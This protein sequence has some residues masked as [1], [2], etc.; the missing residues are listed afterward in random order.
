MATNRVFDVICPGCG[1]VFHETTARF[2]KSDPIDGSMLYL[3]EP[4]RTEYGWSS[5]IEEECIV[6][7]HLV[8]PSCDV[9]Y[10]DGSGHLVAELREQ[11]DPLNDRYKLVRKLHREGLSVRKIVNRVKEEM[12]DVPVSVGTV[13]R[14]IKEGHGRKKKVA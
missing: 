7:G 11:R 3:K 14:I 1:G 6:G 13:Q 4:Y 12:P 9:G 2:S 10:C 8:C 5:F